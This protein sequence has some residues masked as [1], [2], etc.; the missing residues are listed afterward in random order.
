MK[1]KSLA[2][3]LLVLGSCVK[4]SDHGGDPKQTIKDYITKSF[5]IKSISERKDLEAYL[6]GQAQ[7]RMSAWSE[8]QFYRAFVETKREFGKLSFKETKEVNPQEINIV[9]ELSYTDQGRGHD[10]KVT[11]KKMA[12]LVKQGDRWFIENVKNMKE[13]IE[14]RNELALP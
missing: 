2:L 8:A 11:Q 14:Y 9:Y 3:A 6:A 12:T 10:A 7:S 13:M 5:A 1:V 4:K